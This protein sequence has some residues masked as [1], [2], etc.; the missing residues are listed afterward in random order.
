MAGP[1][2]PLSKE[3]LSDV[4]STDDWYRALRLYRNHVANS[5]RRGI[6]FRL[7]FIDWLCIW[8]DSGHWPE[9][10]RL[11]NQYCMSRD[12]DM[13]AYEIGNV[14]IVLRTT[15][16]HERQMLRGGKRSPTAKL[17]EETVRQI[18]AD[19]NGGMRNKDIAAKYYPKQRGAHTSND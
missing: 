12:K 9:R 19:I 4:K 18:K 17:L 11:R 13:G 16:D 7:S 2:L 15:N 1:T 14:S 6:P 5:R 10:G 8:L 3:M